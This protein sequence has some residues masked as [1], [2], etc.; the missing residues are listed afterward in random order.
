MAVLCFDINTKGL[1]F[2]RQTDKDNW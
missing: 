1:F 2:F